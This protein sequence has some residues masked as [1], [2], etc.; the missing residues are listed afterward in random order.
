VHNTKALLLMEANLAALEKAHNG[1]GEAR[2]RAAASAS[3]SGI[4]GGGSSTSSKSSSS[5]HRRL[6]QRARG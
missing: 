1:H 6:L 5:R 2:H 3:S 4:S